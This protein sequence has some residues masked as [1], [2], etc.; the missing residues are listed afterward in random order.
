[1]AGLVSRSPRTVA[2]CSCGSKAEAGGQC[3]PCRA[4]LGGE[5]EVAEEVPLAGGFPGL[6]IVA[7]SAIG[8]RATGRLVSRSAT[9]D[10]QPGS[11][12]V[13]R[14]SARAVQREER[15]STAEL[16]EAIYGDSSL[17]HAPRNPLAGGSYEFSDD[18]LSAGAFGPLD[19]RIAGRPGPVRTTFIQPRVTPPVLV[20]PGEWLEEALKK[21]KLLKTLPDWAREKAIKA[22]KDGDEL[23]AEKII[24]ALPLDDKYKAALTAA[25]KS[26]LQLGK[27]K[28]FKVPESHP[29]VRQPDWGPPPS[30]QEAPGQKTFNILDLKW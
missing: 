4:E 16:H 18:P 7:R 10:R 5:S 26:I 29:A 27:G 13:G 21:D 2:R 12:S 23:A 1:M 22:L 19:P 17:A 8:N 28:T 11:T 20:P 24:G 3:A 15:G 9:A 14:A 6:G 25:I 30:F